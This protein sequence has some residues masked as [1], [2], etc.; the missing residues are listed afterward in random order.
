MLVRDASGRTGAPGP[1][2]GEQRTPPPRAKEFS[3]S[4]KRITSA[5]GI[6]ALLIGSPWFGPGALTAALEQPRS[7]TEHLRDGAAVWLV[8]YLA[9]AGGLL[10]ATLWTFNRALGRMP[11]GQRGRTPPRGALTQRSG[12]TQ[13]SAV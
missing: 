8:V 10:L 2:V 7:G 5:Y 3:R 9:A 12:L 11:Y 13:A 4:S 6:E 1:H